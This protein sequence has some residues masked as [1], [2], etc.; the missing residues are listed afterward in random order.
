VA[1]LC[2]SAVV[3]KMPNTFANDEYAV[4][5]EDGKIK[6]VAGRERSSKGESRGK[7]TGMEEQV[8]TSGEASVQGLGHTSSSETSVASQQTTRS[9]IP[10]DDNLQFH[11]CSYS[12]GLQFDF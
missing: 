11:L 10:E 7:R 1:V 6:N 12:G 9:H 2:C 4:C 8:G 3:F 5:R